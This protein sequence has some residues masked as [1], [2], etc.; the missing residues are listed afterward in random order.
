MLSTQ[1]SQPK[2]VCLIDDEKHSRLALEFVLEAAGYEVTLV[3]DGKS[4]LQQFEKLVAS[5]R[6]AD[7]VVADVQMTEFDLLN[8]ILG[9]RLHAARLPIVVVTGLRRSGLRERYDG[10]DG[11]VM[12]RKPLDDEIFVRT[13]ARLIESPVG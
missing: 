10:L 1:P 3:E 6:N 7:L 4:A 9:L 12:I 2:R 11:V 8:V 13:V 5:G